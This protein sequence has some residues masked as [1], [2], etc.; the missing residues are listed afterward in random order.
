MKVTIAD[1]FVGTRAEFRAL[2]P[3]WTRALNK[4]RGKAVTLGNRRYVFNHASG[5]S[6]YWVS[7]DSRYLVRLSDHWSNGCRGDGALNCRW[8]SSCWWTLSGDRGAVKTGLRRGYSDG[9][10]PVN[11]SAGIVRL[12]AMER[13]PKDER[14]RSRLERLEASLN[15]GYAGFARIL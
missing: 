13:I 2:P 9:Y 1:Y 6:W 8:V 5:S 4:A 11:L 15:A 12:D 3:S 10:T 7:E 14:P